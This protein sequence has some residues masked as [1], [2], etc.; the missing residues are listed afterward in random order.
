[1]D[2]KQLLDRKWG[3]DQRIDDMFQEVCQQRREARAR[4]HSGRRAH[5]LTL[6]GGDAR[7]ASELRIS[8]AVSSAPCDLTRPPGS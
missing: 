2:G 3:I 4:T 5:S 6:M 7:T 1:M 8:D